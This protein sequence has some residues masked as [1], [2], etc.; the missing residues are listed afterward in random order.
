MSAWS[1]R[2]PIA[3]SAAAS[4]SW[5][6]D[7]SLPAAKTPTSRTQ[8]LE[9]LRD[10]GIDGASRPR[11][12]ACRGGPDDGV[13]LAIAH[14][15]RRPD[16]STAAISWSR[17]DAPPTP[18]GSGSSWPASR[19][20][21]AAISRSTTGWRPARPTSGRSASAPA[22][23]SS[24]MSPSTT[25]ASSA[26]NLAGGNRTTRDRL[27]PYCMFTDPPLARVG[28]SE[29]E[30]RRQGIAVRVAKLPIVAV[31][32]SRTIVGDARLHEGA[33]RG[34]RATAFSASP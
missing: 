31:L 9:M 5:R 24:P 25:S 33:G 20:T 2:K 21:T 22:A 4:R 30:A 14:A 19:W 27:I 17:P 18:T 26:D 15:G 23:R 3:V 16:R 32:R 1:W 11:F 6:S 29:G 34:G 8:I 12:S 13:G 28:L 10:E 7:R